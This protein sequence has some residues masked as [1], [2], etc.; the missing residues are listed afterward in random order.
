M[1]LKHIFKQKRVNRQVMNLKHVLKEL[2]N[3]WFNIRL[4]MLQL[5]AKYIL[6]CPEP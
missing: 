2:F 1:N 6:A 4:V 5:K 3:L